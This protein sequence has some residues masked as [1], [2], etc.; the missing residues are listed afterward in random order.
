MTQ[1]KVVGVLLLRLKD[2]TD[3]EEAIKP[4]V[5]TGP[6]GKYIYCETVHPDWVY[7]VMVSKCINSGF[8]AELSI[9]HH[10]VMLYISALNK[11]QLGFV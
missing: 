8:V 3:L 2:W 6:I 10:Y 9:P 1:K 11:S 7:F 5:S 4:Y